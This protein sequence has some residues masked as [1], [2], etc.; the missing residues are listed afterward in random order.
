MFQGHAPMPR[1]P[2]SANASHLVLAADA[3]P[4]PTRARTHAFDSDSF[5]QRRLARTGRPR[6]RPSQVGP[7]RS[8]NMKRLA[9]GFLSLVSLA[10]LSLASFARADEVAPN[11][12]TTLFVAVGQTTAALSWTAPGDQCGN[13]TLASY[14]V[15]YST[16]P[17][18]ECNF[19]S[20]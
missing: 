18:T 14:D 5:D 2:H 13:A 9:L 4:L 12:V 20:A 7:Q 19:E 15:R 8:T 10:S 3:R 17:I 16:S 6:P 11:P 1:T